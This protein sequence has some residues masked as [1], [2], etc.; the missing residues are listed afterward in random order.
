MKTIP[1]LL[2]SLKFN[3][4]VHLKVIEMNLRDFVK[5]ILNFNARKAVLSN[6]IPAKVLKEN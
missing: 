4:V 1:L 3:S 6:S 2:L 5:A